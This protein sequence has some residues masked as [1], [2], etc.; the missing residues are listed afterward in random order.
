MAFYT[1]IWMYELLCFAAF[2]CCHCV[3]SH[4]HAHTAQTHWHFAHLFS[5]FVW[6]HSMVCET[7]VFVRYKQS[8]LVHLFIYV[9]QGNDASYLPSR[10]HTLNACDARSHAYTH[11]AYILIRKPIHTDGQN[12]ETPFLIF[13]IQQQQRHWHQLKKKRAEKFAFLPRT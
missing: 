12:I 5:F 13:Q 11:I 3:H 1:V 7:K 9:F 10:C 6:I 4:T 2:S 8:R